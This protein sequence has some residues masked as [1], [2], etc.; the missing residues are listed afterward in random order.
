MK[1]YTNNP[2]ISLLTDFGLHDEYVGVIKG[3]ICQS[4]PG[5]QLIDISHN[6][7]PQDIGAA[8]HLLSRAYSFFPENTVHLAIVDPGV[9]SGRRLIAVKTD[10]Y[11]FVGPD[12]GIFTHILQSHKCLQVH[13]IT[14]SA[15]YNATISNTFHGRDIMA[16]VAARLASGLHIS[17]V[18]AS[19]SKDSCITLPSLQ[20]EI[21]PTT[22][23][24][25]VI[26][27]DHFGNMCTNIAKSDIESFG[28]APNLTIQVGDKLKISSISNSYSDGG[29]H[30][31][32]LYDSHNQLEITTNGENAAMKWKLDI[33]TQVRVTPQ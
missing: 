6:L 24:G 2:T 8:A 10:M 1:S 11:I 25:E 32:A 27:I 29:T 13:E 30:P 17:E 12:N 9:G 18:G 19:I 22:I 15:L 33:G 31:I 20:C 7:P 5:I 3:V 28:F 16:P 4:Y 26:Y 14:N 21:S 23:S